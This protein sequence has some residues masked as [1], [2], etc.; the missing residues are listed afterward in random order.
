MAAF[1]YRA[2][3]RRGRTRRGVLTGDSAKQ[4]RG[5]LREQGLYPVEVTEV[6]EGKGHS[7]RPLFG[8]SQRI[9]A[10]GLAL[11]TR[12]L[13]TL[14]RSGM[15]LEEAL[16]AL[17]E[18]AEGRRVQTV[19]AGV[20]SQVAEGASFAEALGAF[21]GTFPEI[22]RVM[23]EAGEESG[24]LDDVLERL[25]DYTEQ[26]Q[27]MTQKVGVALIYPALVTLVAIGVVV[28][29]LTY[30]V[31]KVVRV[32]ENTGQELPT[33]T[34][35]ML[36]SSA[37][38]RENW[39]ILL[40]ILGIAFFAFQWALRRPRFRAAWDRSLLRLPVVGRLIRTLNAARLT[41]TLAI[42]SESGVPLLEGLRISGRVIG[43]VP[44]R[45]LVEDAAVRVRE[46]GSLHRSLGQGGYL[47]PM[48]VHMIAA[49]ED[50]GELDAMLGR[51]AA[52]QERELEATV[53]ATTSLVEPLLI[54]VMGGI[55][56]TIVLAILLPIFEMNQM[57][58]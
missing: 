49:G 22:F 35:L 25:A 17:E 18:Q 23:A 38:L 40:V 6:A 16:R 13:A 26:R 39:A 15:P 11:L 46:G 29:L 21:P 24:R 3:D 43:N 56:L 32:F 30:V 9:S 51:A 48:V 10:N 45:A 33:L 5:H 54:L 12:Q 20:R 52:H 47:P 42:M 55:V 28:A 36:A 41:R 1:E 4:V 8:F 37:F 2:M 31:P 19:V 14:V 27:A 44:I 34:Q 50:S 7:G 53:A 58:G 57:V